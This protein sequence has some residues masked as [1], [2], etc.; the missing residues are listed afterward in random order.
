MS[1]YRPI[2]LLS[3]F[4]KLLEKLVYR[5]LIDFLNHNNTLY[6][7]QFG[8]RKNHS[9]SLAL[10]ETMDMI[11]GS[12]D[13]GEFVFGIYFD[14]QKAFDTVD[15]KILL[16]KLYNY[17]IRGNLYEWLVNYLFNRK[18]YIVVNNVSSDFVNVTCGVPQGSVLGPLL[19]F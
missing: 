7:Y 13:K 19:F 12:L 16:D 1:N 8:F 17:G 10:I 18:Q 11:Y 14:L 9:T 3:I 15:H 4:N 2:S 5:R 6:K